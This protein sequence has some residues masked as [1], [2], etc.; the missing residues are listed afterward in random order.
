MSLLPEGSS[1][2]YLLVDVVYL[3]PRSYFLF[4]CNHSASP[5][6]AALTLERRLCLI[7]FSPAAVVVVL[8]HLIVPGRNSY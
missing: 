7:F 1:Y 4:D 6:L 5:Q 8:E 2:S 3:P